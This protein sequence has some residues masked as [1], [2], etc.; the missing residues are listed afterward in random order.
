MSIL[1]GAKFMLYS[2]W[3]NSAES[4]TLIGL[5]TTSAAYLCKRKISVIRVSARWFRNNT[6]S[7]DLSKSNL[8]TMW[9]NS[10]AAL[11]WLTYTFSSLL[12]VSLDKFD[13]KLNKRLNVF[14]R[15]ESF[16]RR[17][18]KIGKNEKGEGSPL[19]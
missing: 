9:A 10:T 12:Y 5:P 6:N 4:N 18:A 14:F 19:H 7:M 8:P 3:A 11:S 15:L 16:S 13:I 1:A 2:S 17:C